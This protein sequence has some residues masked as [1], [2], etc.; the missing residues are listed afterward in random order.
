[1]YYPIHTVAHN[2]LS[3]HAQVRMQQRSIP[4]FIVD[5]LL[6]FTEAVPAGGGS[7][8]YCFKA[9]SWAEAQR[10]MGS[11]ARKLDRYRNAYVIVAEDG[12]VVTA[13]REH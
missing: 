12:T 4:Q 1:M 2:R 8:R 5:C 11:E 7:V 6:D 13:A 10:D 3:R 9:D